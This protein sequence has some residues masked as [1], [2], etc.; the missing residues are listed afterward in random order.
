VGRAQVI[1]RTDQSESSRAEQQSSALVF[2]EYPSCS[3][4]QRPSTYPSALA[5]SLP[6]HGCDLPRG[7]RAEPVCVSL[8]P[9][10]AAPPD[11]RARRESSVQ[12]ALGS[13]SSASVKHA[14]RACLIGRSPRCGAGGRPRPGQRHQK[15][16]PARRSKLRHGLAPLRQRSRVRGSNS[17]RHLV[18]IS[19]H[20]DSC[21]PARPA[22]A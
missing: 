2:I 16:G 6:H 5:A 8:V 10:L 11:L 12:Q 18:Q 9:S 13:A 3:N 4:S 15:R 7:H 19:L 21:W 1:N 22:R 17:A 14:C 20:A